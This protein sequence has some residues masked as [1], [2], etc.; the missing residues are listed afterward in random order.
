M[1]WNEIQYMK[2]YEVTHKM[3]NSFIPM[4]CKYGCIYGV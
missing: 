2:F 4:E 3:E 1:K